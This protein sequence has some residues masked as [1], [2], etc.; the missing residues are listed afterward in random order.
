VSMSV[1]IEPKRMADMGFLVVER[2]AGSNQQVD[3][4]VR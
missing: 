2:V 4:F 1:L 3:R